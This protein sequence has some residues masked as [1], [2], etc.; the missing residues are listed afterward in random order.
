M[1]LPS[2][3][4]YLEQGLAVIDIY[5]AFCEDMMRIGGGAALSIS[6]PSNRGLLE[7][8]N[9]AHPYV[10]FLFR[11]YSDPIKH[12]RLALLVDSTVIAVRKSLE[13]P[14]VLVDTATYEGMRD[15]NA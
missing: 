8:L 2:A 11:C 7:S 4:M 5:M 12:L 14:F 13:E 6:F 3:S 15:L 1:I 10:G 9:R